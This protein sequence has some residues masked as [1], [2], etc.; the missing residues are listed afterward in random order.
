MAA[1]RLKL[2]VSDIPKNRIFNGQKGKYL[3]VVVTEMRQPDKYGNTHTVYIQQTKE[4]AQAKADKI[5]VGKGNAIE[6]NSQAQR[7]VVSNP[8]PAAWEEQSSDLPF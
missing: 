5:Y 2:I 6:F 4:E 8:A 3:D 7:Q 1:I